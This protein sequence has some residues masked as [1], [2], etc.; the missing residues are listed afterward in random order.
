MK[1]K[2]NSLQLATAIVFPMVGSLLGTGIFLTFKTSGINSY[3]TVL[4]TGLIGFFYLL[5]LLYI[6]NY[7]HDKNLSQ[8]ITDVFGKVIGTIL[9]ILLIIITIILGISFFFGTTSF[10]STLLLSRTPFMIITLL[11]MLII[12]ITTSKGFQTISRTIEVI[13]AINIILFIIPCIDLIPQTEID[14]FKPF[15][16]HGFTP[17]LHSSMLLISVS[18]FPIY[19]IFS[20]S[21]NN[22]IDKNKY[23]K[24]II[25]FYIISIF[26]MFFIFF[27]TIGIFGQY[28]IEVYRYPEYMVTQKVSFFNFIDRIEKLITMQWVLGDCMYLTLILYYICSNF[29]QKDD[30]PNK[31]ILIVLIIIILLTANFYFKNNFMYNHYI[32]HIFPYI[33]FCILPIIL[34]V[35]IGVF[36][37]NKKK[38]DKITS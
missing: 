16:E 38:K 3:I 14:N 22:F 34:L 15:L 8:I 21:K 6:M 36:I 33:C 23:N 13:L 5:L 20:S 4:L 19:L 35:G 26:I 32:Y 17:I 2:I 27:G 9:N 7:D 31:F 28:L 24:R 11:L 25:L 10:I 12:Y 37:K 29:K 18:I 30:R 1:W